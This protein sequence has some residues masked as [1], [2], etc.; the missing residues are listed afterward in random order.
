MTKRLFSALFTSARL[1]GGCTTDPGSGVADDT[2]TG[3][4]PPLDG[5]GAATSTSTSTS[6]ATATSGA[7][8]TPG[9]TSEP[10]A[11]DSTS[12][13]A[14]DCVADADCDNGVFCDGQE[15]CVEGVCSP[16]LSP[17]CDDAIA[18]TLDSCDE[19]DGRCVH[20][21]DDSACGSCTETC[22]PSVGC[23]TDCVPAECQGQV[24]QCGNCIDDDG[25]CQVD[26]LDAD[27]WG[28]CDNNESGWSGEVPG[29][30]SQSEC[31]V[32]DCY[33][34]SNSGAG[35]DGCSWSHSC[36]PLE[37]SGCTY[38]PATNLPGTP[39]GCTELQ[40]AQPQEC[41]DYCAPLVPNGCDCFDCCGV[42]LGDGSTATVYLGTKDPQTDLGTCN[43][44]TVDDPALC[45]RCTQ[46]DACINTCEDCEL[47]LGETELPPECDD[48]ECPAGLQP[49]GQAGQDPCP[50]SQAC[51][52]GCCVPRPQ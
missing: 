4:L 14:P 7:S 24:Y 27:C 34:D 44:G 19:A 8:G 45:H 42:V 36:D 43:L 38:D 48:Q 46:V 21:P 50:E 12:G 52:T 18:C 16:G 30:Q 22:V 13:V 26:N 3:V 2:S 5:A 29:Q 1:L 28:P 33:F 47:C 20:L 23:T 15:G 31:N 35:N 11:L 25:D 40:M 51:V 39:S 17:D 49:C 32:M 6:T 37:P 9:D 10:P 41:V